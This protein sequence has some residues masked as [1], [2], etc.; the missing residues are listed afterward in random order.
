MFEKKTN[1]LLSYIKTLPY[2]LLSG[3]I[4][5]IF[6]P[7]KNRIIFCSNSGEGLTGNAK[8]LFEYM[9]KDA[10]YECHYLF[11]VRRVYEHYKQSYPDAIYAYSWRA[12]WL[13]ARARIFVVTHSRLDVPVSLFRKVCIQTWH[14]IPI[15]PLGFLKHGTLRKKIRNHVYKWID[16][17]L[18]NYYLSSSRYVSQLL[19]GVFRQPLEK[20][21]E[22][23]FP[24]DDALMQG[25]RAAIRRKVIRS[26]GLDESAKLV[27]YA[28]TW[29]DY[30]FEYFGF[31]HYDP[32][33]VAEFHA[34][35]Q[36][37]NAYLLLKSH[38]NAPLQLPEELKSKR[39]IDM[40]LGEIDDVQELLMASEYLITDYS[41]ICFD[42][43]I[44]DL[45]M[46]FVVSD[47]E[48]Y[49]NRSGPFCC[50]YDLMATGPKVS[51]LDGFNLELRKMLSGNDTHVSQ[52]RFVSEL[53]RSPQGELSC[54]RVARFIGTLLQKSSE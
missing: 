37:N 44:L 43:L 48:R 35:L 2:F 20:F 38:R 27:L 10:R 49:E 53:L 14:G 13:A 47:R 11:R 39:V 9:R 45:P 8:F 51:T 21:I 22:A 1:T 54:P 50:D 46:V 28:P 7:Q 40:D 5:M 33:Q 41:S 4:A 36:D 12:L 34:T 19:A 17:D 6:S 26:L 24:R 30:E 3:I 42:G 29:R 15:K 16:Y 31:P 23:G 52:R 18:S 25:D 32:Q